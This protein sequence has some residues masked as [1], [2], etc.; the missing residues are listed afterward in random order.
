MIKKQKKNDTRLKTKRE[1]Y[2]L[3]IRV[4]KVQHGGSQDLV[5]HRTKNEPMQ[6]NY[7]TLG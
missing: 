3:L 2:T 6:I 5:S 1:S 4:Q 7:A